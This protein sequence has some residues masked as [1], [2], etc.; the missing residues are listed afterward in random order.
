MT[1]DEESAL[2]EQGDD[3]TSAVQAWESACARADANKAKMVQAAVEGTILGAHNERERIIA[4]FKDR[5]ERSGDFLYAG[6]AKVIE[7]IP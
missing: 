6:I 1:Y 2:I 4:W 3:R 5:A 7:T